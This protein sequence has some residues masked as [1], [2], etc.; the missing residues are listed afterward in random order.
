MGLQCN[1]GICRASLLGARLGRMLPSSCGWPRT[2]DGALGSL[3]GAPS[4]QQGDLGGPN[5][6]QPHCDSTIRFSQYR[7]GETSLL[8]RMAQ[9][10]T[11]TAQLQLL[12]PRGTGAVSHCCFTALMFRCV[13]VY[14]V[15]RAHAETTAKCFLL[16]KRVAVGWD[17]SAS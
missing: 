1:M 12:P 8:R 16:T 7:H 9:P 13:C 17:G 11:S 15:R 4:P 6:T 10:Q 3:V 14:F 2:M 5:S